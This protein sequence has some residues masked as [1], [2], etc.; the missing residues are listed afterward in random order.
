MH[1]TI[2]RLLHDARG[3]LNTISVNAEVAK[4]LVR[5]P[6]QGEAII[7]AMQ[8][9]LRECQRCSDILQTIGNSASG[10][11][12]TALPPTDDRQQMTGP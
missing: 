9:I 1:S 12:M 3:P 8:N 5:K 4:L 10:N 2:D 7:T 6:D 11:E